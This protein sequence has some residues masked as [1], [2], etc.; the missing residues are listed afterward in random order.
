MS[1]HLYKCIACNNL[2]YSAA[3]SLDDLRDDRCKC[4]GS[5]SPATLKRQ[6]SG[7]NGDLPRPSLLLG[8]RLRN[9]WSDQDHPG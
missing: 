7:G 9:G 6:G 2:T 8:K 5:S 4:G 3:T 1:T